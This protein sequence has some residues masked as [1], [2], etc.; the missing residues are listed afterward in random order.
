[1][2]RQD[3]APERW[4][5]HL[6]TMPLT[7]TLILLAAAAAVGLYCAWR[8]AQPPDLVRGPRMLPYRFIMMMAAAVALVAVVHLVNLAGF[9]TGQR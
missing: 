7:A 8:G 4:R 5:R 2:V 3:I 9:E 6:A 1:M